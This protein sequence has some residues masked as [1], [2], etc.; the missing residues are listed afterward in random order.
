MND[1]S[2]SNSTGA[3]DDDDTM[4]G[5]YNAWSEFD[6]YPICIRLQQRTIIIIE[7]MR[8]IFNICFVIFNSQTKC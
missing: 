6:F 7:N 1:N 5:V 3:H 2:D 4:A 8:F